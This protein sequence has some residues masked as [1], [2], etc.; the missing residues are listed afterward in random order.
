M[1]YEVITLEGGDGCGK[2]TQARLLAQHL[3][4][5]ELAAESFVANIHRVLVPIRLRDATHATYSIEASV[6]EKLENT[7]SYNFV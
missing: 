4:R 2:S 5:E 3:E 7:S 6:L 1:L